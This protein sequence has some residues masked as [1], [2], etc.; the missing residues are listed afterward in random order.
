[1]DVATSVG[2]HDV[3]LLAL[4][5]WRWIHLHWFFLWRQIHVHGLNVTFR[6]I[7][8]HWLRFAAAPLKPKLL[9][10]RRTHAPPPRPER[11]VCK[12]LLV[13]EDGHKSVT[14]WCSV[15]GVP[16]FVR[17]GRKLFPDIIKP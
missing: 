9:W 1:M 7:N 10:W 3:I 11:A 5:G 8:M 15:V 13:P 6:R 2:K 12:L 14:D 16:V 17:V 4:P